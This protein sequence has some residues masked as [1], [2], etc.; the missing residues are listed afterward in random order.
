VGPSLLLINQRY[1]NVM[2]Q[3]IL[4]LTMSLIGIAA[5]IYFRDFWLSPWG[6]P[7]FIFLVWL[8]VS[9]IMSWTGKGRPWS[10]R[11]GLPFGIGIAISLTITFWAGLYAGIVAI[12]V[13]I[14]LGY[15]THF[16]ERWANQ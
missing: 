7:T 15:R 14:Y 10:F 3:L 11:F 5:G 9:L 8:A 13:L 1:H 12:I 2:K 6:P 4:R 16:F